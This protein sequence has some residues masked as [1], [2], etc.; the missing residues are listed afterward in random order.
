MDLSI[1]GERISV[2]GKE[3]VYEIGLGIYANDGSFPFSVVAE[4]FS[5]LVTVRV[6]CEFSKRDNEVWIKSTRDIR[7]N[8][9]LL[10]CYSPDGSY[11]KSIFTQ[12]QLQ[13][14]REVLLRC[15]PTQRDAENAFSGLTM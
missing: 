12:S 4:K 9:E 10:V 2:N 3:N 1:A 15:G 5:R 11:W 6:N 14:I 8:E 7:P 13:Q